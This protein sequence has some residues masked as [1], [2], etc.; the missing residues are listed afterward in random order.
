M[1]TFVLEII[2]THEMKVKKLI[3]KLLDYNL[4]AEISVVAHC[5]QE[6]FTISYGGAEGQTRKNCEIVSIYVDRLCTN[7]K[8]NEVD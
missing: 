4:D 5:R 6:E 8:A 7:E 1:L 3:T 2:I